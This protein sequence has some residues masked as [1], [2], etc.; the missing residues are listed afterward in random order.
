MASGR[1]F[2]KFGIVDH[3]AETK[4]PEFLAY[5]E[6]GKVMASRCKQ[7]QSLYFPPKKDCPKCLGS[8]IE[9]V[10]I[11]G[12]GELLTYSVVNYGPAGFEDEAP[13][14]LGLTQFDGGIKILAT[15][16]KSIPQTEIKVG[17]K[18]RIVPIELMPDRIS[19]AFQK[20]ESS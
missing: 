7:C 3:T 9:W 15:L 12:D 1:N 8:D 4:I 10:E 16:N 11:K 13:Y 6:E 2:D 5:L 17:M 20:V 14:T 18:L 19:Y